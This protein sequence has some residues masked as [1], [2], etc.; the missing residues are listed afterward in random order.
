MAEASWLRL[1]GP[2]LTLPTSQ[3]V[4]QW[5]DLEQ[6]PHPAT[7]APADQE[8]EEEEEEGVGA[9]WPLLDLPGASG[10]GAKGWAL[11][12]APRRGGMVGLCS[13]TQVQTLSLPSHLQSSCPQGSWGKRAP[14]CQALARSSGPRGEPVC[15][16]LQGGTPWQK[17]SVHGSDR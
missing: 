4:S 14:I 9:Q 6:G 15:C 17:E 3:G 1:G 5:Q 8:E 7:A 13:L 2:A 12:T 10:T 16:A 11:T